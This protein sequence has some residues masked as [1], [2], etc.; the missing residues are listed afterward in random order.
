M[1][2]I[3]LRQPWA[4]M[5]VHGGKHI[6]NRSWNTKFRGEFLIHAAKGMTQREYSEACAWAM[7]RGFGHV[8]HAMRQ[9]TLDR[10]GIVGIARLVDVIPP[11]LAIDGHC[12]RPW[13]MHEQFGFVLEDVQPLPF[14][15]LKGALGFFEVDDALVNL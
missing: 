10:G 11:E 8:V 13:H 4:W 5:V 2:A 14:V 15:P 3:S 1:K 12:Q 9:Q 6:E 7:A